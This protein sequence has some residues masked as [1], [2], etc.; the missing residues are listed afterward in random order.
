MNKIYLTVKKLYSKLKTMKFSVTFKTPFVNFT[1]AP[2]Y[3]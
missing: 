1:F 2:S 3:V